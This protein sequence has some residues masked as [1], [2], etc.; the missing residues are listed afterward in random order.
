MQKDNLFIMRG[1][2]AALATL[3]VVASVHQ[4]G[5]AAPQNRFD[6]IAM[7]R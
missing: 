6:V 3:V 1:A 5:F 4:Q 7:R 2:A